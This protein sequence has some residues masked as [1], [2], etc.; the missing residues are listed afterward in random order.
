MLVDEWGPKPWT[1]RGK[2]ICSEYEMNHDLEKQ[3]K[4]LT[5]ERN[6]LVKSLQERETSIQDSSVKHQHVESKLASVRAQLEE[7]PV[8]KEKL[9]KALEQERTY[10]EAIDSLHADIERLE[11]ELAEKG[12]VTSSENDKGKHQPPDF[13]TKS[14]VVPIHHEVVCTELRFPY[15]LLSFDIL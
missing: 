3:V 1:L 5:L 14:Q 9:S 11:G 2:V 4:A 8:L 6:S 10:E 12:K 7:I 15:L 13:Q